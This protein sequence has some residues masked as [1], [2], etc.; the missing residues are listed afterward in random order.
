[1]DSTNFF[2]FASLDRPN[3][4]EILCQCQKWRN[5]K[6]VQNYFIVEHTLDK[7]DKMQDMLPEAF[8]IRPTSSF[9]DMDTSFDEFTISNQHNRGFYK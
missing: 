2:T 8:E 3:A 9:V 5:M 1:M 6:F 7:G 4:S